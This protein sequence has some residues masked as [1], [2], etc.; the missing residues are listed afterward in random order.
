MVKL[1]KHPQVGHNKDHRAVDKQDQIYSFNVSKSF[2][3]DTYYFNSIP[4]EVREMGST[5]QETFKNTE[6]LQVNGTSGYGI[7]P[8]KK[9][10]TITSAF[11]AN[12]FKPIYLSCSS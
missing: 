7:Q 1:T 5:L 3:E 8:L 10:I 12:A 6:E 9:A 11:Q 4:T 2:V